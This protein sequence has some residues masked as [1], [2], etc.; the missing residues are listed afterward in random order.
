MSKYTNS[1]ARRPCYVGKLEETYDPHVLRGAWLLLLSRYSGGGAVETRDVSSAETFEIPADVNMETSAFLHQV[2][3]TM[4]GGVCLTY[5]PMH[6]FP[7]ADRRSHSESTTFR[8]AMTHNGTDLTDLDACQIAVF[9]TDGAV[10]ISVDASLSSSEHDQCL[11]EHLFGQFQ[12]VAAQLQ[13][14]VCN[15]TIGMIN[16]MG[17]ADWDDAAMYELPF[18]KVNRTTLHSMMLENSQPGWLAIDAWDGTLTYAELDQL[19]DVVAHKLRHAGVCRGTFVPLFI[20]KSMWHPVS[21][22]ACSKL[23]VPWV[24][25]PFELPLGRVQSKISQLE[26]KY[27]QRS[28][29]C[30][31]S[32]GQREKAAAFV[33]EVIEVGADMAHATTNGL[34]SNGTV[35]PHDDVNTD[36]K[37]PPSSLSDCAYVIFTSGTT[38]APKGIT[39]SQQNICSFIPAWINL[40]GHP[41]GVGIRE[42]HILSHASDVSILE[43]MVALC[44]GSCLCILSEDERIDDLGPA[45][46]RYNVTNL[47][48]TPSIS[49]IL[50]PAELPSLRHI[51]FVGEWTTQ[52]LVERWLKTVDVL[53]TYGPA[54][55]TNECSGLHVH[56]GADFGNGCIGK[57]FG[58]RMYIVNPENL[59]QRLPRG[60][61]GEIIV[62]GPGV[63]AGY[64]AS[65]QQEASAFV[66][67][68]A[69][70]A[71]NNGNPRRFYR[72]GD[73][74]YVDTDNLFFCQGRK[75]LQVKIRG[76]RIELAEVEHQISTVMP[77]GTCVVDAITLRTGA[78][79]LVA[80][81]QLS[82]ASSVN[83]DELVESLKTHLL[84][85]LPPTFVPSS[86]IFVDQIPLGTTGKANRKTLRE[87]A[88]AGLKNPS[89]A[90]ISAAGTTSA[91]N[92][93]YPTDRT[94][95]IPAVNELSLEEA[96]RR[97]WASVLNL[98]VEEVLPDSH[99]FKLGGDSVVAMKLVSSARKQSIALSSTQIYRTPI[100]KALVA[101]L[102]PSAKPPSTAI[103]I[104]GI[105]YQ[106]PIVAPFPAKPIQAYVPQGSVSLSNG[107]SP[108]DSSSPSHVNQVNGTSKAPKTTKLSARVNGSAKPEHTTTAVARDSAP[109]NGTSTSIRQ[110][111]GIY[112]QSKHD[113]ANSWG[114]DAESI[115]DVSHATPM[116]E[117]SFALSHI[118]PAAHFMQLEFEIPE[119]VQI[120]RV[121]DAWRRVADRNAILRTRFF[122]SPTGLLQVVLA[123]DFH[124]ESRLEVVSNSARLRL[125]EDLMKNSAHLSEL[126]VFRAP[127]EKAQTL[128][129][130]VHHALVDP[131]AAE[132]IVNAVKK[133]YKGHVIPPMESLISFSSSSQSG[134]PNTVEEASYWK[135]I[136]QD[137]RG[138]LFP[139]IP[140]PHGSV[141]VSTRLSRT[142]CKLQSISA[143]RHNSTVLLRAAWALTVAKM[144]RVDDVLFGV[145]VNGRVNARSKNVAGPLSN[146]VP[147]RT[148]V[149]PAASVEEFLEQ[150][151]QGMIAMEPFEQTNISRISNIDKDL[152]RAC[153]FQ[154]TLC[155]QALQA[156]VD[157]PG[158]HDID[159]ME[160]LDKPSWGSSYALAVDCFVN[161]DETKLVARYDGS[162][163][164]EAASEIL[165]CFGEVV[166]A[167]S[168]AAPEMMLRDALEKKVVKAAI[169]N[170]IAD[171]V[172]TLLRTFLLP[173]EDCAVCALKTQKA[174]ETLVAFI[175]VD[176]KMTES[177]FADK[178][179]SLRHQLEDKLPRHEVPSAFYRMPTSREPEQKRDLSTSE[180]P[181][182]VHPDWVLK[183]LGTDA[184]FIDDIA[185]ATP[186]QTEIVGGMVQ[187][188]G[189]GTFVRRYPILPEMDVDRLSKAWDLLDSSHF[190]HGQKW[191]STVTKTWQL[192]KQVSIP[193]A[194]T[195]GALAVHSRAPPSPT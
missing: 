148:K 164:E 26:D 162:I 113:I 144:T 32:K 68:L 77:K 89:H 188:P 174:P 91:P 112:S 72:T 191:T 48:T 166:Q 17:P 176:D 49:E 86:F 183:Q 102:K 190:L 69:W 180:V 140:K 11:P 62:E 157:E 60:F 79:S 42:G 120:Q 178:V 47:H 1:S 168:S 65:S 94:N 181:S 135:A 165:A 51:H 92:G 138:I 88:E 15:S 185:T 169:S 158:L 141:R 131:Y 179:A 19:S 108:K 146:I 14:A 153:K 106:H 30:L 18:P 155:I 84:A 3:Q 31:S 81:L 149:N 56:R 177:A 95:N 10:N 82:E 55:I 114:I 52:A 105:D 23:G 12:T 163:S 4:I 134:P 116:Q 73:L 83:Q 85:H 139:S 74:G 122:P 9:V 87:M 53:V 22:F 170:T 28:R 147:V 8:T 107:N 182:A 16:F 71:G 7:L 115:E 184:M 137:F 111:N 97:L 90:K 194:S 43:I 70:A 173:G 50:D 58:S 151:H 101:A 29:V 38:G 13:N 159:W 150:V 152:Q 100:L 121:C 93:T 187:M 119:D 128:I 25:I 35:H 6:T 76:Q 109:T 130:T 27:G 118:N 193:F 96:L 192:P 132:L 125:R 54:E 195:Q 189:A 186:F 64:V 57:P 2:R 143:T 44:T 45:L 145:V 66:K 127:D 124:W 133:A 98:A 110:T 40:R 136:L 154:N 46:A 142:A 104:S 21:I 59:H 123:D 99:F 39:I 41:G 5:G 172:E 24:T 33:Q 37:L 36:N 175:Q 167:L 80:F 103:P 117:S 160:P 126:V 61:V 75:D 63:S 67:D 20:E 156:E 161:R 171:S 129:W 34:D 78:K